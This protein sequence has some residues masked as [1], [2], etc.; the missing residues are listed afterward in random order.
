MLLLLSPN[1][2]KRVAA[3]KFR[4]Y[5]KWMRHNIKLSLLFSQLRICKK[6]LLNDHILLHLYL[7]L[8]IVYKCIQYVLCTYIGRTA[9]TQQSKLLW[10]V[11]WDVPGSVLPPSTLWEN[12]ASTAAHRSIL[13]YLSYSICHFPVWTLCSQTLVRICIKSG[14]SSLLF[15]EQSEIISHHLP[16]KFNFIWDW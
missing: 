8:C 4:I 9:L 5:R 7:T 16:C 13:M 14:H 11:A 3:I 10:N 15:M 2:F 1:C 6:G 12:T